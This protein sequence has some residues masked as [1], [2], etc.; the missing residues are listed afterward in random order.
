MADIN[1]KEQKENH[2]CSIEKSDYITLSSLSGLTGFP[3][4][5]IKDELLLEK[6]IT[7]EGA[8]SL[9]DLRDAMFQ[10]LKKTSESSI[11]TDLTTQ[12]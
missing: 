4:E 7:D 3:E 10:Y 8:L 6:K 11:K 2:R 9:E 1:S 5:L 12:S